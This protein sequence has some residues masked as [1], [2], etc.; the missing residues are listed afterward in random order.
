MANFLAAHYYSLVVNITL[1]KMY[2][3]DIKNINKIHLPL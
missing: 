1:E 3:K 2:Q